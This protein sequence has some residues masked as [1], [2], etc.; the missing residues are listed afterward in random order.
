MAICPRRVSFQDN[1]NRIA[2]TQMPR[3]RGVTSDNTLRVTAGRMARSVADRHI[4]I[5]CP[6][7]MAHAPDTYVFSFYMNSIIAQVFLKA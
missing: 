2:L 4:S 6:L 3:G 7:P 1:P 5:L